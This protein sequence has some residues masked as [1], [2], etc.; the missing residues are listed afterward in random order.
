VTEPRGANQAFTRTLV[1][2]LARAGVRH[3]CISPGSRSGPLA[4]AF[5]DDHRI[6]VHVQIDER[7]AA[8]FALGVAKATGIPAAV[9][10]TS[11]TAAANLFPAIVEARHSLVPMLVLTADRPPELRATG[12]NQTIDQIKMYGDAVVWFAEV[13]TPETSSEAPGYWRSLAARAFAAA[14]G[15]PVHLNLPLREPLYPDEG[16]EPYPHPTGG[17]ADDAPWART[18]PAR[19]VPSQEDVRSAVDRLRAVERGLV[20]AGA[21]RDDLRPLLRLAEALGWPVLAEPASNI[22]E[23]GTIST[24]DALLRA[25][26]FVED[27]RPQL[28]L[29][30]GKL[31]LGRPLAALLGSTRQIALDRRDVWLDEQRAVELLIVSDVEAFCAAALDMLEPASSNAWLAAWRQADASARAAIDATIDGLA[32]P[33]EPRT[34]RDLAAAVPEGSNLLAASSMPVRDL[35]SFM[36]P[37]HGLRVFANRGANGIDGTVSTTLGIAKASGAPTYALVGDVALLHDS[38]GL[39]PTTTD[40]VTFVILNNDGGGIFSFLEQAGVEGFERVFG[41]PH[42]RDLEALAHLHGL[43]HARLAAPDTLGITIHEGKGPRLIEVRTDR[44]ANVEVHRAIW[45]AVERA[46]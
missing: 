14:T 28:V 46:L 38:N 31:S 6:E 20:V 2:E 41:T 24:Y 32:E 44:D 10:C 40:D 5:E 17:R 30:T 35:E 18:T 39:L 12:A 22:R 33:S 29:R 26:D 23:P 4:L 13:G 45:A 16:T 8:F 7:S 1:D 11:G 27:H 3:A 15:G 34:A 36:H 9:V 25:R 42:G 43:S 19:L 21:S 37:R